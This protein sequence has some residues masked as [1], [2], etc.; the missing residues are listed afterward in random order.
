MS[1]YGHSSESIPQQSIL[2][3]SMGRS[4]LLL[5]LTNNHRHFTILMTT[6]RHNAALATLNSTAI[7]LRGH[8]IWYARWIPIFGLRYVRLGS[9]IYDKNYDDGTTK[10][11]KKI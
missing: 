3:G 10:L 9:L 6:S 1:E 4:R 5:L 11:L 2:I 7:Y 8:R